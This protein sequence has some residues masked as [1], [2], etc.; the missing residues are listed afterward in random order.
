MCKATM[1]D[2]AA[3]V[4]VQAPSDESSARLSLQSKSTLLPNALLLGKSGGLCV[5]VSAEPRC[6]S[7]RKSLW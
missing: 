1:L 3:A 4:V 5:Q 7:D 2:I 6:T